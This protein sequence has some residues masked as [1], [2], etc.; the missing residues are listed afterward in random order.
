VGTRSGRE[1][2]YVAPDGAR[3]GCYEIV[4][5]LGADGMSEVYRARDTKLGRDVS[6]KILPGSFTHDSERVA[7]FRREAQVLAALNHPHFA[8][9]QVWT[10][11]TARSSAS[12]NSQACERRGYA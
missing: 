11:R 8:Q 9:V 5:P 10:S 3:I 6:L 7:R 1:L 2:F 12:S 4:A